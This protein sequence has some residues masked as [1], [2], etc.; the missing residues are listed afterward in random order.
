MIDRPLEKHVQAVRRELRVRAWGPARIEAAWDRLAEEAPP[1]VTPL[2]RASRFGGWALAAAA[3]VALA[4]VA[5]RS[6]GGA[7][8]PEDAAR[9]AVATTL[10]IG[11]GMAADVDPGSKV[12]VREKTDARV[13]VAMKTGT[14]TFRVRHDPRRLFRVE[15]GG[16]VVEDLGTVFAVEHRGS[17]VAVSVTEGLVAVSFAGEGGAAT[18]KTLG[19]G[20]AGVF[21]SAAP[22]AAAPV[23]RAVEPVAPAARVEPQ[24][25]AVEPPAADWRELQRSGKHRRAYELLAPGG[26]KDVRDEPGDLLL[27]SDAARLSH[28]PADAATLLRRLLSRHSRDPRA[29]SAAF[30]LGWVLLNELGRP[31]EAARAFAQAESL[32]PRGNLAE[33]AVARAVE[34][35]SRAGDRARARAELERYRASYPRGRHLAM[36]ER[37]VRSP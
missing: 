10:P 22:L 31:R 12:E 18:K 33:D 17:S 15:A 37:V 26:F 20:E 21:P 11:D 3:V 32:A 5:L 2:E 27:A 4:L 35:W 34:A 14:A 36:L 19:A 6:L 25:V 30:T 28:H 23:A 24:K 7:G 1:A 9:A 8:S 13:V 16:V 29:P